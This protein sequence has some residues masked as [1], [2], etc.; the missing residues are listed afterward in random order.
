LSELGYL[1]LLEMIFCLKG[2]FFAI[3]IG[4]IA[5]ALQIVINL[6]FGLIGSILGAFKG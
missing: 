2:F 5:M 3:K 4:I 6:G 1:E